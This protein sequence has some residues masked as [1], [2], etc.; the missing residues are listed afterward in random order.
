MLVAAE[1]N[2]ELAKQRRKGPIEQHE[3][4]PIITQLD[5]TD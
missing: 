5:I 3:E 4:P 1:L 2:A